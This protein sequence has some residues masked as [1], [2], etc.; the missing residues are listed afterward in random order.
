[1]MRTMHEGATATSASRQA[2]H[3]PCSDDRWVWPE[4][5]ECKET[6]VVA[7]FFAEMQV[8]PICPT[9]GKMPNELGSVNSRGF[10]A[11]WRNTSETD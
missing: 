5:P 9:C 8:W 6:C 4:C 3:T 1:M 7:T 11:E 2:R 10:R